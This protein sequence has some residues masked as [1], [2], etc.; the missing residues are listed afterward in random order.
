MNREQL[1]ENLA[2]YGFPLLR[3]SPSVAEPEAVLRDLLSQK[4]VRLL[5][6]FPVVLAHLFKERSS[7]EW[8]KPG[9]NPSKELSS[10]QEL[11]L[12]YLLAAGHLLFLEFEQGKRHKERAFRLLAKCP[13]GK[14]TLDE[15][16]K[17][18]GKSGAVLMGNLEL[19]LER[20]KTHFLHYVVEQPPKEEIQK[21]RQTLELELLLSEFF[22]PRQKALLRKRREGRAFTKTE[23]EYFYRVV[24]KRLKALANEQLHQ[25]ARRE[26]GK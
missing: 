24:K 9:W 8:E 22:T 2:H 21:K 14:E 12:R 16:E 15:L 3:V 13:K 18:W 19:S 23:R 6:G 11:R 26:V 4:D 1:L 25:F 10:T 7:L 20:L 5:E 17:A